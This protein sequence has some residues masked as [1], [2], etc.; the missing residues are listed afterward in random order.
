MAMESHHELIGKNHIFLIFFHYEK[1][2]SVV[3]SEI[4][5]CGL[6]D[7]HSYWP[8]GLAALAY[9]KGRQP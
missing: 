9:L 8:D 7:M 3:L 1:R 5:H 4:K 6:L 2:V